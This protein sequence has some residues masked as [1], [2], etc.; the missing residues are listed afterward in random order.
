MTSPAPFK[1][2]DVT[3]A[4]KGAVAAGLPVG[5]CEIDPATGVIRIYTQGQMPKGST[6]RPDPDELLK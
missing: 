3:R 1:Q 5:G 2:S 4:L 6:R